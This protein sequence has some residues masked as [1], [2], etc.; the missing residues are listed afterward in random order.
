M[1]EIGSSSEIECEKMLQ[2]FFDDHQVAV[3]DRRAIRNYV[4]T[5]Q[6]GERMANV[7]KRF[8]QLINMLSTDNLALAFYY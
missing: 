2:T 7:A 8:M 6:E 1:L 5:V 4:I 3:G